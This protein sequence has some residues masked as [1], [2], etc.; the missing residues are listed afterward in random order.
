M[1][2]ATKSLNIKN[3]EAYRLAESIAKETGESMTQAVT[4]ALQERL[5]KVMES[6]KRKKTAAALMAIGKRFAKQMKGP[7]IDIDEFL[8]DENGLPK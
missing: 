5:I 4:T 6:K 1:S 8:Y 3:G 7:P 2:S